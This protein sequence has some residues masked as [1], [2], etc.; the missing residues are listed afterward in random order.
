LRVFR[1]GTGGAAPTYAIAAWLF[2]RLLGVVYLT[3]FGSLTTQIVGLVGRQGIQPIGVFLERASQVLPGLDRFWLFPT[4][5]WLSASDAFLRGLCIGGSLLSM[6]LIAGFAPLLVLPLLWLA[7]L[8]LV[9][10][11]QDFLGYQWDSLLLEAGLI[12]IFVAPVSLRHRLKTALDPPRL[13]MV[14]LWWLLF[15]LMF[16][17]GAVKL[18]SG[19]PAWRNLTALNF[20]FWTQPLPTPLAWYAA[21]LPEGVLEASTAAMLAIELVAPL[22]IAGPRRLKQTAC[23]LLLGLQAVIALTGNY[24]FFNLLAGALCLLLLD[25]LSL[26]RLARRPASSIRRESPGVVR[27][28]LLTAFASASIVVSFF[29]L[30]DDL[31]FAVPGRVLVA[32]IAAAIAPIRSVN[33]YGLFAV[34]TLQ[35]P[36]IIIE[37]SNDGSTWRAYGFKYQPD[38]ERIRPPWVAPHQPRLD[39][40]L[41]FAALGRYE[42][43]PWFQN[44]CAR[45]LEASPDVLGLLRQDPF[46]GQRPRYVRA[47]LYQYRF[48]DARSGGGR[49]WTRERAGDYSPV[50]SLEPNGRASDRN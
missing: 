48:A 49:W 5:A 3:A 45:L 42:A 38:D 12:A 1:R 37:G 20:H 50:L 4:L 39:W 43:E 2:L 6:L 40:Q 29:Q 14:L 13:G 23:V 27:R 10:A 21:R 36:E 19:D 24:A 15:R 35:R 46:G 26:G 8:S 31:G 41:W 32:P 34:M 9:I 11:G 28:S 17:S 30:T 25:D 7:Y 18:A 44:F 16:G 33:S 47:S 22:L